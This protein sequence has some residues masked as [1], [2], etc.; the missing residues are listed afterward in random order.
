MKSNKKQLDMLQHTTY[1]LTGTTFEGT[2]VFKFDLNG[3]LALFAIDGASLSEA[4]KKWLYRRVPLE[5]RYMQAFYNSKKFKIVKGDIDLSFESFYNTYGNKVHKV[6]AEGLWNKMGTAHK[7]KALAGIRGYNK[8]L[9]RTGLAKANPARY[10]RKRYY[11]DD[12]YRN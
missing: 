10:L 9:S 1:T 3:D 4:Q 2:I 6:E 5:E 11:E 12:A 8:Y 7:L